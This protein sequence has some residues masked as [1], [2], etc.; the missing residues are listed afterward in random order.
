M[1]AN[2]RA[3]RWKVHE[4]RPRSFPGCESATRRATACA[5]C[6]SRLRDGTGGCINQRET[7]TACS[8]ATAIG[9]ARRALQTASA[10]DAGGSQRRGAGR[11]LAGRRANGF[12]PRSAASKPNDG[13]AR[14]AACGC[15]HAGAPCAGKCTCRGRHPIERHHWRLHQPG[16]DAHRGLATA[17]VGLAR[18]AL[19]IASAGVAEEPR[20]ERGGP[21]PSDDYLPT[22][23]WRDVLHRRP[24]P[25]LA[26]ARLLR[27]LR[28]PSRRNRPNA[29]PTAPAPFRH[30]RVPELRP[31]A[32][33]PTLLNPG[34][35]ASLHASP[36]LLST[37]SSCF[38]KAGPVVLKA[39][40]ARRGHP[41]LLRPTI[42]SPACG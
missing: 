2:R 19:Q 29:C 39:G 4:P 28:P 23:A 37:R 38:P 35:A 25:S 15:L 3:Q 18:R 11:W 5:G 14:R 12:Q 41:M 7:R 13:G 16:P 27:A 9:L 30:V 40:C 33:A 36:R 42:S 26:S 10:G 22:T 21:A 17:A 32:F 24:T 6:S 31:C 34:G 8:R 1:N 20:C